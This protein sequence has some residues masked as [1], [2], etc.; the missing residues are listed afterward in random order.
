MNLMLLHR[1]CAAVLEIKTFL[2]SEQVL[3]LVFTHLR[4]QI[5]DGCVYSIL[6][7]KAFLT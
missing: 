5:T 1:D 2:L 6:F 7:P 3:S 4:E